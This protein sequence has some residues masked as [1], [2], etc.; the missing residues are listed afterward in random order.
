VTLC[1]VTSVNVAATLRALEACLAQVKF[2]GCLLF[3]DAAVEISCPEIRVV[4]IDPLQSSGAYSQFIL[5]ELVRHIETSHCLLAQWDGHIIDAGRWRP[6]FLS[7]DYIG[8][9]WPQ[10][11]DGHTVG[12]GGFSLRSKRLMEASLDPEF[13]AHHPE[14]LAL[15]RTN[16]TWLESR[17][18][19]FAPPDL[20]AL[21]ST[22][23]TGD[24]QR[25]FGYHGVFNMPEAIG[26]E[27]FWDIYQK[28]DG[29]GPVWHDFGCILK[30]I[31]RGPGGPTRA[32]RFLLDRLKYSIQK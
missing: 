7:Y 16:R 19:R 23:R 11:L 9:C 20:A 13:H 15:C 2:Q 3:T 18:M 26:N 22:E 1:A 28:L 27:A 12:N 14:D 6:D 29:L 24:L 31:I 30:K 5:T 32:F 4:K 21:F 10:F 8:A 17:G 25:S